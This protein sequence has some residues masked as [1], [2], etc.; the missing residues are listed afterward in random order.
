VTQ[1]YFA[2]L[3]MGGMVGLGLMIRHPHK[4]KG[5]S[6]RIRGT[7]R[8]PDFTKAWLDRI[9]AVRK[10]AKIATLAPAAQ[11]QWRW[12][13]RDRGTARDDSR[14]FIVDFMRSLPRIRRLLQA[15]T[16]ASRRRESNRSRRTSADDARCPGRAHVVEHVVDCGR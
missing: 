15:L 2:G 9:A 4:I 16:G 3:S 12:L 11:A 6:S 8:R 13:C 7:P 1:T 10:G 14:R 5:V